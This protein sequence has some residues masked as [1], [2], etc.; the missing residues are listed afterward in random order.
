MVQEVSASPGEAIQSA[1]IAAWLNSDPPCSADMLKE[2]GVQFVV[3]EGNSMPEADAPASSRARTESGE[4]RMVQYES[5]QALTARASAVRPFPST[6]FTGGFRAIN[7]LTVSGHACHAATCKVV[8][9]F[10]TSK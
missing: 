1:L 3:A 10:A 4:R 8:L 9:P 7:S 2:Q 6:A 5:T